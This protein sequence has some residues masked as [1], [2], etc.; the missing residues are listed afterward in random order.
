MCSA[1]EDFAVFRKWALSSGYIENLTI[2]RKD[3]TGDYCESN[4]NWIPWSM[5]PLN[6]SGTKPLIINGTI[7]PSISSAAK[8]FNV[9]APTVYNRLRRGLKNE[10]ALGIS[11]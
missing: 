8:H 1:W 2:E 9:S 5:Q 11:L 3:S 6:R 10:Q 4:C 7:F